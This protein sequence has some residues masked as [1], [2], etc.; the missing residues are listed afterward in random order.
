MNNFDIS[1]I[2]TSLA[3]ERINLEITDLENLNE[4]DSNSTLRIN[5]LKDLL[6][7]VQSNKE[8]ILDKINKYQFNKQ[9]NKLSDTNKIVKI[10]EFC[11]NKN[12]DDVIKSK[13]I[14]AIKNKLLKTNK[15][16]T[17]DM[18]NEFILSINFE[19]KIYK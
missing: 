9:W 16:V 14:N 18:E 10:I 7:I 8:D 12:I 4:I 3:I 5:Y 2:V 19:K 15:Q 13:L 6:I 11:N 1:N 17:Y